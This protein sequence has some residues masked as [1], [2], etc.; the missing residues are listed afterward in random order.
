M[1][2]TQNNAEQ[3]LFYFRMKGT[4]ISSKYCNNL[5]KAVKGKYP[6]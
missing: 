3:Y 2:N 1:G 5:D 6:I 4:N